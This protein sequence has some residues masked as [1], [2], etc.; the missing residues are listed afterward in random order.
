[1]TL[2]SNFNYSG[3][4]FNSLSLEMIA[5]FQINENWNIRLGTTFDINN[6]Q[7]DDNLIVTNNYKGERLNHKLGLEY[8]LNNNELIEADS[9]LSYEIKGDWGWYL[10]NN[11]SFDFQDTETIKEANIQLKKQF[12]CREIIFSYDY[13]KDEYT[14]QYSIN[15]FPS[16]GVEFIKNEDSLIFDSDIK[17]MLQTEN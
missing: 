17:D 7:F 2:V 8:D 13:L 14:V 11:L 16:Q 5:N 1:M 6:E 3:F 12:H 9:N 15:L 4:T 10:E